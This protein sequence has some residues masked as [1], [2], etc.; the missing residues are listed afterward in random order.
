MHL[1]LY[2]EVIVFD[3]ATKIAYTCVWLHLDDF[4]SPELAYLSGKRRLR[5]MN[6]KLSK[7]P[8]LDHAKVNF[9]ILT[10]YLLSLFTEIKNF[11]S[12]CMENKKKNRGGHHGSASNTVKKSNLA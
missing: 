4:Q 7:V 9:S 5:A 1:S 8:S 12:L 11:K 10:S 2:N 3:Q 6:E